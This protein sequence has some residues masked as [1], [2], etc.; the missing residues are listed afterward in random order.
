MCIIVDTNCAAHLSNRTA[1]GEPVLRWLLKGNGGLILGGKLASELA[2]S[3]LTDVLVALN[4]AGRLKRVDDARVDK[5][6]EGLRERKICA[7]NDEHVLATA[8]ASG[9][10]LIFSNDKLLH[11]DAKNPKILKPVASIYKSHSHQHLLT[12]CKC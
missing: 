1:D 11:K 4:R 8:I 10:R 2:R 12:E 9:C 7:S 3:G 5:I 6:S